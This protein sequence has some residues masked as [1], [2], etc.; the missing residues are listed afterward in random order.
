MVALKKI[1]Q[2]AFDSSP[3]YKRTRELRW[4]EDVKM[5]LNTT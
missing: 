4:V 3:D 5:D 2:I 1:T